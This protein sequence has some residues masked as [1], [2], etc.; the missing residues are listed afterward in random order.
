MSRGTGF[1]S[2]STARVRERRGGSVDEELFSPIWI[3]EFQVEIL[4]SSRYFLRIRGLIR[5]SALAGSDFL[6]ALGQLLGLLDPAESLQNRR[7]VLYHRN[8]SRVASAETL[9]CDVHSTFGKTFSGFE[10]L[11][12]VVKSR[13]IVKAGRHIWMLRAQSSLPNLEGTFVQPLRFRVLTLIVTELR[14]I[15]HGCR[16]I[17]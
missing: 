2:G 4:E 1:A 12:R 9:L 5:V 6:C 13:Q 8:R 7:S 3:P 10:L 17:Y 16:Y 14:L 11:L 15:V